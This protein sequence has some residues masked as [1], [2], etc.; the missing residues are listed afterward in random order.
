MYGRKLEIE[1]LIERKSLFLLGPRQTGKTTLLNARLPNA[2]FV[3]LLRANEFRELSAHPE[4]LRQRIDDTTRVVVI[5]EVQKLPVILDE[6]QD[7]IE[8]NKQLRF[9]L[10]GSSARKLKRG[11]ANLLGGRALFATLHPL[12]SA[13]APNVPIAARLERGGLPSIA[14]SPEPVEDLKAYVGSY[15]QEEIRGE[16]LTRAIEPFSRFLEVA[17]QVNTELVNFANV[18]ND[19]QVPA[20]TVR[21][22]FQLLEDTL[23]GH[24]LSPFQSTSRRKPVST[25]KFYFFDIGVANALAGRH[26]IAPGTTEYGRAFEHLIFLELKAY[27]DY[28]RRN[29]PL[30]FWRTQSKL[31]VDFVV[32]DRLAIEVKTTAHVSP[33][34]L[35]GLR[36]LHEELPLEHR[37]VVCNEREP[38]RT[39]DGVWIL[40]AALFLQKLWAGELV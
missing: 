34:M 7:L 26:H 39:P 19:A 15:L 24:V 23:V 10:T 21:E 2:R 22:Y 13:E 27:L 40:P 31:E 25:A 5:D 3:N 4:L 30:T 29:E 6:V 18:G 38:R 35:N 33:Q 12:I 28:Q 8:K 11:H 9:V 20:R 16:G 36:A 1:R 32:G 37:I 14:D 17:G